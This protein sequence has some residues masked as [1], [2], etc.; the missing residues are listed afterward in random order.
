MTIP[1]TEEDS[2]RGN[3][4]VPHRG[5]PPLRRSEKGVAEAHRAEAARCRAKKLQIARVAEYCASAPLFPGAPGHACRP[6]STTYSPTV[7]WALHLFHVVCTTGPTW[8]VWDW[9]EQPSSIRQSAAV[10]SAL[11]GELEV[12][13]TGNRSLLPAI[14]SSDTGREI[15][16]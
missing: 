4:A 11:M 7:L 13:W 6:P 10:W 8:E 3:R 5:R 12:R 16:Q 2:Q 14:S 9:G 15:L 1:C